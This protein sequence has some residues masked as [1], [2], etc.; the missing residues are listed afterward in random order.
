V[1]SNLLPFAFLLSA[2]LSLPSLMH[3][4]DADKETD[5]ALR[6]AAEAAKKMGMEMPDVKKMMEE[7][8]KEEA[9]A[10]AKVQAVVS[11]PGPIAFPAWIPKVPDFTPAGPLTKKVIDDVP[12]IVQTGTSPRT[13]AELGDAWEATKLDK[14]VSRGR[15]NSNINDTK[16]VIIYLSTQDDPP[17]EVRMEATRAPSEKITRVTITSPLPVPKPASDDE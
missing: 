7:D 16:T 11:A 17:Q 12:K 8:E 4:Q 2:M 13:P 14:A 10:K 5:A 9:K 3:A 6:Q 15:N 1:K